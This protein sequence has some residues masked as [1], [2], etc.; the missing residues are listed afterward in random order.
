MMTTRF[1]S[2][3]LVDGSHPRIR[4]G[5]HRDFREEVKNGN[6]FEQKKQRGFKRGSGRTSH[7]SSVAGLED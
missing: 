4:I 7:H 3:W 5:P 6:K 1:G 2:G